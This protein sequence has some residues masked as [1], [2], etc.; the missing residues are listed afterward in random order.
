MGLLAGVLPYS[1]ILRSCV[2]S[3]WNVGSNPN[4]GYVSVCHL[5]SVVSENLRT[6]FWADSEVLAAVYPP[7]ETSVSKCPKLLIR[8]FPRTAVE[9]VYFTRRK[10]ILWSAYW[11][12]LPRVSSHVDYLSPEVF[13]APP[14]VSCSPWARLLAV[15]VG[16]HLTCQTFA[17]LKEEELSVDTM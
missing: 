9:S 6:V 16:W 10:C 7:P 12:S 17:H 14:P 15:R 5:C 2:R 11:K 13:R 3:L 4:Q 8:L 1:F